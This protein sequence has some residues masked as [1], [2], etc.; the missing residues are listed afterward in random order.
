MKEKNF[1]CSMCW[2]T[3]LLI[4]LTFA[5]MY[6]IHQN[7]WLEEVTQFRGEVILA[8]EGYYNNTEN[9]LDSLN[10]KYDWVDSFD[11]EEYEVSK[12][13]LDSLYSSEL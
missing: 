6:F 3:V 7:R 2:M 12:E 1:V 11:L 10:T 5:L 9:L 8:Y 13:K 4:C